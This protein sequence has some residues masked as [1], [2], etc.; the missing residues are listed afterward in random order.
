MGIFNK[1]KN[2]FK[3]KNIDL[4]EE[5]VS[6][7]SNKEENLSSKKSSS[8]TKNKSKEKNNV[9]KYE[10][11]LT[12][13]RE[14]FV[15]K[16]VNLTNKYDKINEDFFEELEE[17]LIMADI[18]VNTVMEFMDKLR[19]RVRNEKIE[20]PEILKEVIVDELFIIYV[21]D[22]VLVNK[23]NFAE[24]GPTVILFVGVNGVGKTTTIGKIAYKLKEEG[25]KVLLVGA[26]TFRA[27]AIEQLKDWSQKVN[28]DFCSK[29][30][31]S[32]PSSVVY[33]GVSKAISEK[34]DVV[35][36]D[37]AGRLQNKVNLMKELEKMNKVVS[38]LIEGGAHET[39]LVL[40][41]T[42]GQNGI[43]QAK[44]FKEIT[45]ITGI[46][47]TKLDGTAKGGIVLAIKEEVGLPVKYIGLGEAKD[48]LEVF[49]I[50]KY[51]YGLF[52]DMM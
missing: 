42:T 52:K 17:I 24:T 4:E 8:E 7:E 44:S 50:E 43:S 41:A 36:V 40:D 34:Y 10:K 27:G 35:L 13:S 1:L 51:I 2:M 12:K 5:Q 23:I 6:S 32:D 14:G 25:K 30:E 46:V 19:L 45:N 22:E 3:E 48:D 26:D 39:L 29:E 47:L 38:S 31:G 28:V 11:G 16:L 21:N 33:D 15:S 37:T 49:D 20:D 9:K 18:G